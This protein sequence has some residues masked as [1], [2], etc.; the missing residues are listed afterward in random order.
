MRD[1]EELGCYLAVILI[2]V[3]LTSA[4]SVSKHKNNAKKERC[5]N[6]GYA[7]IDKRCLD[8]KVIEL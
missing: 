2:V 4:I 3:A 5:V 7:Y 8:V 1:L 6:A